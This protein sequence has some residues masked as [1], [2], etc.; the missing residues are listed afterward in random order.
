[1]TI[2]WDLKKYLEKKHSIYSPTDLRKIINQE[3]GITISLQNI[4][5]YF[6]E[7]PVMIRLET[8]EIICTALNCNLQDFLKILP[9]K[10]QNK[11]TRKLSY[12]NTPNSKKSISDFP[13]PADYES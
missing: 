8:M 7:Q 3:T 5:N 9:S 2:K 10:K 11:A 1:M 12:K 6:N 4:C 13:N